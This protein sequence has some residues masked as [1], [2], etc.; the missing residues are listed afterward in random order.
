MTKT[1]LTSRIALKMPTL[2]TQ[3]LTQAVNNLLSHMSHT[4]EK[5]D[6]IELRG[7][8]SF[9][10]RQWGPRHA[11]NPVTGES[12][13]TEPTTAVHFKAGRI[14]RGLLNAAPATPPAKKKTTVQTRASRVCEEA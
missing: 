8:G 9:N 11:R 5:G 14:L 6:R 2:S 1:E 4:L 12:W 7:F 3:E 10:L 13:R